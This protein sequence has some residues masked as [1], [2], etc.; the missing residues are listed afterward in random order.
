M[1]AFP[2]FP[3]TVSFTTLL[4]ALKNRPQPTGSQDERDYYHLLWH[5]L[6]QRESQVRSE[7]RAIDNFSQSDQ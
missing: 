4:E 1:E 6:L 7:Q 3:A 2:E 5:E